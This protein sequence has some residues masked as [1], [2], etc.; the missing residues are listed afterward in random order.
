MGA[1][2]LPYNIQNGDGLDADKVMANY[3]SIITQT[4][5]LLEAD[6]NVQVLAPPN[7]N[8]GNSNSEGTSAFLSRADHQHVIQGVENVTTLPV[9][10]TS[11]AASST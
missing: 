4:N 6:N 3:Q 7:S 9:T 8:V 5:G 11:S 2:N 1:I 10:G